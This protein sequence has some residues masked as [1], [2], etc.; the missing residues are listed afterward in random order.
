MNDNLTPENIEFLKDC[1][2]GDN[3]FHLIPIIESY[4]NKTFV[5]IGVETGKSSKVLL[6]KSIENNNKVYGIDP[7]PVIS[8]DGIKDHPNYTILKDDSVEV[9][10]NWSFAKPSIVFVDSIHVK[11][12][13]MM[14]LYYWW[15][16]LEIGGWMVFHDT[17]WG[18]K[19]ETGYYIHKPSHRSAGKRPGNSGQGYD[20]YAGKAWETPEYAIFDF[21]KTNTQDLETN[22]FKSIHHPNSL[23]M[24]YMQKKSSFDFKP[25]TSTDEWLQHATDRKEILK[26]F[27]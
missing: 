23:G 9:G 16:L 7:I 25:L 19:K 4:K 8:I 17:N 27:M 5:D 3:I 1:E 15:D 26:V 13:V 11:P 6:H 20:F 21:F 22:D 18:M 24:T 2:L 12:Q 14:E 10:K